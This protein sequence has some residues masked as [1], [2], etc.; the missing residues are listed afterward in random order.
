MITNQPKL[1]KN[2]KLTQIEKASQVQF[3]SLMYDEGQRTPK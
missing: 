1:V 2:Q 3:Y